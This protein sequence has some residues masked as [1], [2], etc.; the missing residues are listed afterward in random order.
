MTI[1]AVT[2]TKSYDSTTAS[3]KTPT[4]QV[5]S[6]NTDLG[7]SELAASTLYNSDSFTTLSESFDSANVGARTLTA[8]YTISPNY[9]VTSA[10]T[11]AG[12]ITP[13]MVTIAAV[14]DTK[15]Y[16]STTASSKT[17][18]FQVTSFNTDLG[19]SEMGANTLYNSDAFSSL[20]QS[21]DSANAGART[22][23]AS[24]TISPNYTVTSAATASGTITP[25]TVTIAAVTDTKSYDSTTASSKTPTFQV[26]SFNTDLGESELGAQHALQ[27]RQLHH[28]VRELRLGQCRGTHPDGQL[29][30]QP[31][32]H[33]HQSAATASGTI[34]PATVTV[35]AVTDTKYY[36]GT[37]ASSKTPTF[38]VTSFN[39]DLGE[40]ELG[41]NTLYNSDAFSS[42]SQ[43]F[44][45]ANA[46][47]RTLTASYSISPNYTVTSASTAAGTITPATVTIAAVTDTRSYDSTTASSKTPTFQ[48]TSFNTDL[49]EI[50]LS[51]NT[52]YNSDNFTTLSESFD[53][54]NAG[55]RTLTA[56][57]TISPN[58][59][60]TSVGRRGQG[61]IT[62][63]TVTIA[64]VTDTKSYDSTTASSKTP[65]FQVTSFNTDLGESEMERPTRSTTAM[66]S[67]P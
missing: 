60:V 15:S 23:T 34:T 46:G 1:A 59:T 58:Y 31:Q 29:H 43:S 61:T 9:T 33:G 12:T 11:A 4:F 47:S 56:S 49:G 16:D 21:F 36:D 7:E 20:S 22:L 2:D 27:Q 18:T 39:T 67:A 64:A 54:A 17:P 26:T 38:Q 32:L 14:T 63:A 48:V 62:P 40:S 44:D 35:A 19:E 51:A 52:L 13:A 5:T 41:A 10:S 28:A 3:S 55:A 42:L 37:T 53:S 24:Y 50:E 65:T 66:R 57:Y 25:A 30:D 6:F 45:S 8:S